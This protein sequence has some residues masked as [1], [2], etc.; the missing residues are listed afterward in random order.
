MANDHNAFM[1]EFWMRAIS[2]DPQNVETLQEMLRDHPEHVIHAG[3][4]MTNLWGNMQQQMAN[5]K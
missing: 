5:V 2:H 3:V 1:R 4:A